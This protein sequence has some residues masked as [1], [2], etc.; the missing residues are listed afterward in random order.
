MKQLIADFPSQLHEALIIGQNHRFTSE[1]KSFTNVVLTGL[2]GSG[3]G[4]SIVQN[5]VADK[6]R[7]P[8]FVNKDY[9]LP[10]FVNK[11]T[12]VIVSSYSGN[13]EET[14]AAMQQAIKLKA[15]IVCITS[16]G[17]IAEIAR[18]KKIDCV[19][20]PTGMPPR[21]CIGYSLV[22]VLY[23][24]QYFDL[25]SYNFEKDIKA[26]IKL[27]KQDVKDIQKKAKVVEIGRA[28]V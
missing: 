12:L 8:F 16:G 27:L 24:L 13:T 17:K 7:I 9:F 6:L 2:G 28:H 4:G 10:A 22:Q 11:N 15:T 14:I 5:F 25:L 19:L 1:G 20:L 21:A 26:S 3:I 23:T 18:K